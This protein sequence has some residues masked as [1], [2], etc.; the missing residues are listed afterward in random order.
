MTRTTAFYTPEMVR[1]VVRHM[2]CLGNPENLKCWFGD[3][4][5]EHD[6][7]HTSRGSQ[8]VS[9]THDTEHDHEHDDM[10]TRHPQELKHA[11]KCECRMIK[12]WNRELTCFN[13]MK[14]NMV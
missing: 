11:A 5:H 8:P 1:R 3:E 7:Y 2:K 14:T 4:G 13:C 6:M 10:D 9:H 12:N